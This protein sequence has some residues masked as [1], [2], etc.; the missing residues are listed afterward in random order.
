MTSGKLGNCNIKLKQ[1]Q[2]ENKQEEIQLPS[3]EVE[4]ESGEI[5]MSVTSSPTYFQIRKLGSTMLK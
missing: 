5:K 3:M 4:E 2:K 1:Q